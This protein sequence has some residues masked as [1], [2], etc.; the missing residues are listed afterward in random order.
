MRVRRRNYDREIFDAASAHPN[1]RFV[2][3]DIVDIRD[4]RDG[5]VIALPEGELRAPMVFQ[6]ARLSP[7]DRDTPVRHPLRQHFGGWEVV[8][9][10]PVFD[11]QVVTLMCSC[12]SRSLRP[13]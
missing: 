3:Q 9:E 6:S 5:G 4:D 1:V 11:P 7:G 13:Q 12:A 10:R 2:A 8:T